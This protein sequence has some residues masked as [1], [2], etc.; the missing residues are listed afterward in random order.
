MLQKYYKV[1][2]KDLDQ[3]FTI[4]LGM[5]TK[6]LSKLFHLLTYNWSFTFSTS[7]VTCDLHHFCF[8]LAREFVRIG[9]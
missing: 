9:W 7:L 2:W 3:N 8:F 5:E 4:I 1:V 6:I